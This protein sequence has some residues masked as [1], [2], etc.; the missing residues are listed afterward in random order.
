M[1]CNIFLLLLSW[2]GLLVS[3]APV[4]D[5]DSSGFH[6]PYERFIDAASDEEVLGG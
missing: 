4:P 2:F 6:S 5:D 1:K 3:S